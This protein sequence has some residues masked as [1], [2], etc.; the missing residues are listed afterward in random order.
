VDIARDQLITSVAWGL[1]PK[2]G[3]VGGWGVLLKL[4]CAWLERVYPLFGRKLEWQSGNECSNLTPNINATSHMSK[5]KFVL[6]PH[7]QYDEYKTSKC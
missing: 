2:N 7:V 6:T 5:V 4:L 1:G 3:K